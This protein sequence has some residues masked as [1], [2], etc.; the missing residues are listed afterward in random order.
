VP[1]A[2][3]AL[4]RI[5]LDEAI[6]QNSRYAVLAGVVRLAERKQAEEVLLGLLGRRTHGGVRGHAM[7]VLARLDCRRAIPAALDALGDPDWYVR[8]T[9]DHALRGFAGLPGGVGYE[10]GQP[11]PARWRRW[12]EGKK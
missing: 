4:K 2:L 10:A 12:W 5:A 11:D 9:A 8:A 6:D 3:P 7:L 1:E